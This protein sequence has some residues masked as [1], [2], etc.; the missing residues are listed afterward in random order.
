MPALHCL[1]YNVWN[2]GVRAGKRLARFG[3]RTA[4]SPWR[5][6][7]YIYSLACLLDT[8]YIRYFCQLRD[9]I[10]VRYRTELAVFLDTLYLDIVCAAGGFL[11]RV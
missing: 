6:F 10:D 1:F 5:D 4:G 9:T 11:R 7:E 8:P 3:G 2:N